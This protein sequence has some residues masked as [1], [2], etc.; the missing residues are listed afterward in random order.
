M[1]PRI[2]LIAAL[3]PDRVIGRDN[4]LP[5]RIRADL[6]HFRRLTTGKPVIMGRRNHQS[7]GRPLPDRVNIIITRNPDFRADGCLVAHS[8]EQALAMAGDA[9]EIMIIGGAE[10][11][12]WYL[13]QADRLYLTWVETEIPGDTWFPAFDPADWRVVD[14][15]HQPPGDD[16]PFPL[17]YQTLERRRQK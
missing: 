12:R 3:T 10:I 16:T 6:R 9:E 11:Y 5:W 13:P 14:E 8:P 15:H 1:R 7:I 4:D 17:L 2:A